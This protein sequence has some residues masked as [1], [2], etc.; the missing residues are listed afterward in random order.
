MEGIRKLTLLPANRLGLAKKGRIR[1]GCDADLCLF[2]P[3]TITDRAGFGVETC[4][5]PPA[6]IKAVICGGRVVYKT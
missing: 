6:G 5:L 2:D 3:E 1:E 4:G